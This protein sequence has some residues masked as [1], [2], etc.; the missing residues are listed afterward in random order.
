MARPRILSDAAVFSAI[1]RMLAAEGEKSVAFSS[2]ARATGLSGAALVQRYGTLPVMVEAA[3][4]W[5]WDQLSVQLAS[6]EADGIAA[7]KAPQALLRALAERAA[8]LPL[9]TLFAASQR[10]SALRQRA[11]AWRARVEA[12]VM[13]R[14]HDAE[15]AAMLF[16]LWQ[17]QLLWEGLGERGFR[18]KDAW[19]RLG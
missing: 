18:L 2:V 9:V 7:D 12:M 1:L 11:A 17:G 4:A 19:K 16:A 6:V 3:L 13:A 14:T 8:D 5:G 10:Y 15:A